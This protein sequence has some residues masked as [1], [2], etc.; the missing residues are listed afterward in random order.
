MR[1]LRIDVGEI[2]IREPGMV[3]AKVF[4]HARINL[5]Y[6]QDFINAIEMLTNKD[7]HSSI[8]DI[9]GL[10]SLD[11]NAREYM[12]N[13]CNEWGTTAGVA[14]V[15]NSVVSR[16]IGNLFLT[17][18]RPNYPIKIFKEHQQAYNWAKHLYLQ[19]AS[20]IKI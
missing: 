10:S 2:S 5:H 3:N 18:T 12:V 8:I 14:F 6:A 13:T 19:R 7:V 9:T 11:Q 16:I 20:S 15:S 4:P 1:T 17:V